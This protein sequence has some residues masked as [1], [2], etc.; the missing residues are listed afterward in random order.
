MFE[1]ARLARFLL[2]G[3]SG[4]TADALL[5][6]ALVSWFGWSPYVGRA[7]SLSVAV[8]ITWYLNRTLT[9]G[10]RP[11]SGVGSELVRYALVQAGGVVVNYG[12]FATTVA[13]SARA[14][15]WPIVALLPAAAAA[16]CFTYVG[17]H[18]FAFPREL[19]MA[20]DR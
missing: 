3:A 12:V 5:L 18:Y 2:A 6:S 16:M 13:L 17:M 19:D 4:F 20:R 10:D 7:L 15:R 1:R 14:E 11:R 9:F 8:G